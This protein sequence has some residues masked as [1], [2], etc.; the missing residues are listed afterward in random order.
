MNDQR[1]EDKV[2]LLSKFYFKFATNGFLKNNL[3]SGVRYNFSRTG[4]S[5]Y[6]KIRAHD[7]LKYN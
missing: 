1:Y 7:I 2:N 5:P 4:C 6:F 3:N